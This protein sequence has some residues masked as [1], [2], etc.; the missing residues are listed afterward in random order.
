MLRC[1]LFIFCFSRFVSFVETPGGLLMSRCVLALSLSV[2]I[3]PIVLPSLPLTGLHSL[4]PSAAALAWACLPGHRYR[5]TGSGPLRDRSA[6][7]AA[8]RHRQKQSVFSNCV[9]C[10]VSLQSGPGVSTCDLSYCHAI[11]I[12]AQTVRR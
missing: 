7:A 5:C 2:S 6:A 8:H 11:Q 4:F 10:G 12:K 1:H 3:A 9:F